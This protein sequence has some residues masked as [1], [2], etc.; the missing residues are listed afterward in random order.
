MNIDTNDLSDV[1]LWNPGQSQVDNLRVTYSA[2]QLTQQLI[3]RVFFLIHLLSS[4][5]CSFLTIES[6]L[7]T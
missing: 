6:S 5:L 2:H 3:G 4:F 7:F 1:V